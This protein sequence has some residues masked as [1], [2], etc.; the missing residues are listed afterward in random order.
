MQGE[1]KI[2]PLDTGKL[3]NLKTSELGREVAGLLGPAPS[4]SAHLSQIT[5]PAMVAGIITLAMVAGVNG[6]RTLA[7]TTESSRLA[8]S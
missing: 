2:F 8:A 4:L 6:N 3:S 1:W 5:G 7:S